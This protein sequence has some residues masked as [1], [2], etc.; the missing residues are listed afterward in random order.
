[1]VE[2]HK[3]NELD[4]KPGPEEDIELDQTFVNLVVGIHFLDSPVG[5]QEFVDLPPKFMI[6][7]EAKSYVCYF[8]NGDDDGDNSRKNV[9]WDGSGPRTWIQF[10][11]FAD[12]YDSVDEE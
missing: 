4:G 9:D 10:S 11:D 12:L 1:V 3:P 7:L 6:D 2:K 5:A 8:G